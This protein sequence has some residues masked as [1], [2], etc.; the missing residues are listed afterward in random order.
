MY[1]YLIMLIVSILFS[2]LSMKTKNNISKKVFQIMSLLPFLIISGVRYNVGTDYIERYVNGFDIIAAGIELPSLELG[3]KLLI[4]FCLLFTD[5]FYLLFIIM[6]CLIIIP[7]FKLIYKESKN[8]IL[9]ILIFFCLCFFFLSLNIVRQFI[10]IVFLLMFFYQYKEN[11]SKLSFIWLILAFIFHK[12]AIVG[13]LYIFILKFKDKKINLYYF[14]LMII[15]ILIFKREIYFVITKFISIIP[16][17]KNY[18]GSNFDV[19][20]FK[21]GSFI[22]LFINL[23]LMY[24]INKKIKDKSDCNLYLNIQYVSIFFCSLTNIFLLFERINFYFSIF[25]IFSIPY[26]LSIIKDKKYYNIVLVCFMIVLI[27]NIVYCNIINNY[28][29]VLPYK[30]IFSIE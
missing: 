16:R 18:I 10:S 27:I 11:K 4:K 17:Y 20:E 6:S 14:I 7:L 5:K 26:F 24:L 2:F 9:S 22:I 28:N 30:T 19:S 25:Q 29:N 23:I 15:C 12:S 1:V 8:P 13:I 3:F 21:I